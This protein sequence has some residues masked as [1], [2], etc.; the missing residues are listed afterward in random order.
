[1]VHEKNLASR[2]PEDFRRYSPDGGHRFQKGSL[3]ELTHI[4]LNISQV[5]LSG[6]TLTIAGS[7]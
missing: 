7:L 1:M 6:P 2:F 5:V 4:I 3:I